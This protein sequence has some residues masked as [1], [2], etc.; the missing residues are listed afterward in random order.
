M[1]FA[2]KIILSAEDRTAAAFAAVSRNVGKLGL[3]F[4]NLK[5]GAIGALGALAVPVSVGGIV[6]VFNES[7]RAI[8]GLNDLADASGASVEAISALDTIARSTGGNLETVSS[9]LV[10]FNGVLANA[11]PTKGVGATLKA[12]GLSVEELKRLDPAEALRVTAVAV[13]QLGSETDKARVYQELFG[14]SVRDAAPFF[15]DLA[16]AKRLDATVTKEQIEQVDKFNKELFKLQATAGDAGRALS[17]GLATEI[18]GIIKKFEDAEKAGKSFLSVLFASPSEME[19]KNRAAGAF[20]AG[21]L[22]DLED[23]RASLASMTGAALPL[24]EQDPRMIAARRRVSDAE[25]A[26]RAAGGGRGF[27]N[28]PN[29]VAGRATPK[30]P[31]NPPDPP[32]I[33]TR[34]PPGVLPDRLLEFIRGDDVQAGIARTDEMARAAARAIEQTRTPLERLGAKEAELAALRAK[35][36]IDQETYLRA[37]ADAQSDYAKTIDWTVKKVED[38]STD[39]EK[40]AQSLG[41]AFSSTFEEAFRSGQKFSDLLKRLAFDAINI[42]FLA[43]M[44][45]EAGKVAGKFVADLLSFDGGGYTGAGSRSGG[46]D[47]RGG[48]MAM[49]HPNETVVDHTRGQSAGGGGVT[50]AQTFHF[51]NADAATVG[52]LRAEAARI[53]AETLAAV[54]AAMV[55]A[56]RTSTGVARAM[57]GA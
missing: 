48:F 1:S 24:S 29:V 15:K 45:K 12:I 50:I 13:E 33:E 5:A 43:P 6:S 22:K 4:D 35:G 52:Q 57:R 11:D 42:Q 3:D 16:E 37:M 56:V 14:K 32:K 49:L 27:I 20:G 55:Q 2:P 38:G 17:I 23:A 31:Q 19:R 8:D 26:L 46:L 41:D 9:I 25:A 54:P 34:K 53:K 51:G 36:Y 47:G 44:N 10:K 18:N 39:A 21:K 28:P 40:M 30:P 7:R